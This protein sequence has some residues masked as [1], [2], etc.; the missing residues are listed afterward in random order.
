[1]VFLQFFCLSRHWKRGG[2]TRQYRWRRNQQA[3]ELTGSRRCRSPVIWR[4]S[5]RASFRS[6]AGYRLSV[7]GRIVRGKLNPLIEQ[8]QRICILAERMIK[9]RESAAV[10][11]PSGLR[12]TYLPAHFTFPLFSSTPSLDANL[13]IG[14][15][16]DRGSGSS[17]A[18]LFSFSILSTHAHPNVDMTDDQADLARLEH[19]EGYCGSE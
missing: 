8:W 5:W 4:R 15:F 11:V 18:S 3:N 10:R 6:C 17:T 16:D 13:P 14:R 1:M 19:T 12:R 2:S 7:A 9:R